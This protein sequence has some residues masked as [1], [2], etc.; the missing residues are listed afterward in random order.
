MSEGGRLWRGVVTDG[1]E[2]NV[3]PV[4]DGELLL[5]DV[6]WVLGDE[7]RKQAV[8]GVCEYKRA[9]AAEAKVAR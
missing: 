8:L 3:V 7:N 6:C 1:I 5:E 2:E 4:S 9:K